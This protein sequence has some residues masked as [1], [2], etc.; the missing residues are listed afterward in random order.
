MIVVIE[1]NSVKTVSL[2]DF[3]GCLHKGGA[4]DGNYLP[5]ACPGCENSQDSS[6]TTEI[7]HAVFRSDELANRFFVSISTYD[8]LQHHFMHGYIAIGHT[9]VGGSL[10]S[11]AFA[12]HAN[13]YVSG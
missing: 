5:C 6:A 7:Q 10:V 11:L 2:S 12:T 8:I 4:I 1:L 9:V 3:P 13:P